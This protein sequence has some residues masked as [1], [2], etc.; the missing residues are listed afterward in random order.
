M[1]TKKS[2]LTTDYILPTTNYQI[3]WLGLKPKN[4]QERIKKRLDD[5]LKSGMIDEVKKLNKSGVGW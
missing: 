2:S 4:L 5:R 1:A 3:L